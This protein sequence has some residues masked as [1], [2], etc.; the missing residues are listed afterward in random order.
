MKKILSITLVLAM[1]LSLPITVFAADGGSASTTTQA[2]VRT[3]ITLAKPAFR[4]G[5]L[6][7][8][9]DYNTFDSSTGDTVF[10]CD[11]EFMTPKPSVMNELY[12]TENKNPVL[13]YRH[14]MKGDY[15]LTYQWK[16]NKTNTDSMLTFFY[17][18]DH[19]ALS[20]TT[21][22]LGR[23]YMTSQRGVG[24]TLQTEVANGKVTFSVLSYDEKAA[25]AKVAAAT[26]APNADTAILEGAAENA[27][28]NIS[29]KWVN[30]KLTV[31]ASLA[32]DPT[33]TTGEAVFNASE[34]NNVME[35]VKEPAGFAFA[36]KAAAAAEGCSSVGHIAYKDLT[37]DTPAVTEVA[38]VKGAFKNGS[39]FYM[40]D[41]LSFNGN[42]D[43]VFSSD[44]EFLTVMA[45]KQNN[46]YNRQNLSAVLQSR[47]VMKGDYELSYQWKL[48]KANTAS[49]MT[50][51]YWQDYAVSGG[52]AGR[53]YMNSQRGT[54]FTLETAV[55]DGKVGFTVYAYDA[56]AAGSRLAAATAAPNADSAI[57]EGAP[58]NAILNV[59]MK[60]IGGKLTVSVSLA[61]DPSKTTGEAVFDTSSKANVLNAVTDPAGFAFVMNGNTDQTACSS[62]GHISYVDYASDAPAIDPDYNF[63]A[64]D[65]AFATMSDG[66]KFVRGEDGWFTRGT[67]AV[68]PNNAA[69]IYKH[70]T[71]YNYKLSFKV[72]L[73]EDNRGRFG[74]WNIWDG[75]FSGSHYGYMFNLTA[76]EGGALEY[77]LARYD[78][79]Y[80]SGNDLITPETEA[81]SKNVKLLEGQAANAELLVTV[82]VQDK[83]LS[84]DVCLANDQTKKAGTV[85]YDFSAGTER[86]I[87]R[88]ADRSLGF[89][90]L[91]M[92]GQEGL[93]S[94]AY[95]EITYT[96]LPGEKP[97]E[98]DTDQNDYDKI[99]SDNS[100]AWNG[101]IDVTDENFM[102]YTYDGLTEFEQFLI[103]NGWL[104]RKNEGNITNSENK[105][106]RGNA[107]AIAQYKGVMDGG[108]YKLTFKVKADAN[109]H[110]RFSVLTRWEDVD[111]NSSVMFKNQVGYRIYF[112]TTEENKLQIFCYRTGGAGRLAPLP[113]TAANAAALSL[114]GID[115][116]TLEVEV[117]LVMKG[118][119]I[120][121]EAHLAGD[122]NKSTGPV[123]FDMSDDVNLMGKID[124]TQGFALI[125]S[126]NESAFMPASFGEF[127][128]YAA[129]KPK[130]G[131]DSG[132]I[133]DP[134]DN[135]TTEDPNKDT[136][137]P[138]DDTKAPGDDTTGGTEKPAE[139]DAKGCK[140]GISVVPFAAVLVLSAA[141][142]TISR[143]RKED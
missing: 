135:I 47:Q 60:W 68:A 28:L 77:R 110:F 82:T 141:A 129:S 3:D 117:T 96:A 25:Y 119:L 102:R 142:V 139:N 54:G 53:S 67:G 108:D 19:V 114:D 69:I 86:T 103:E 11:G 72:R 38:L 122:A 16:L 24:F 13:Q 130:T 36:M 132:E 85:T 26:P 55:K 84:V 21:G 94:A 99:L 42:G 87:N 41:S 57:L 65:N 76:L 17:W 105:N 83:T 31:S 124:R 12:G 121:A 70:N 133:I 79:G 66:D 18:Q 32:S 27:I 138:G 35:A 104:T 45:A 39:Q 33:K 100:Y 64:V 30:G 88:V 34:K 91:D 126:A 93:K 97:S 22:N 106:V 37:V 123:A 92:A 1:L 109:N 2:P 95:G 81:N 128:L 9:Y 107:Y 116:G 136:A 63:V 62:I 58:E 29:M 52:N 46:L 4:N 8:M 98:E 51:F 112:E 56:A 71:S 127:K 48:N 61:S 89:A 75:K 113:A 14:A 78:G 59:H 49:M 44:G 23:D 5:N 134:D 7:Y 90:I 74:I 80:K 111:G 143:K 131:G 20:G 120:V 6:F 140:S 43:T 40:Y 137:K 115:P 15:E 10:S 73:N 118:D 50:F 125:D 101:G